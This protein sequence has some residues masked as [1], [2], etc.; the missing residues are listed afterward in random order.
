L[1]EGAQLL[2]VVSFLVNLAFGYW[3]WSI[4]LK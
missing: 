4:L 1:F 2:Y 3:N